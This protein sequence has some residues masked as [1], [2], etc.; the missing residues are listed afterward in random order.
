MSVNSKRQ[1][2]HRIFFQSWGGG[3]DS[4]FEYLIK[5]AR[6]SNTNDSTFADS[7]VAAVESSVKTLIKVSRFYGFLPGRIADDWRD[8]YCGRSRVLGGH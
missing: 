4:F 3:S 7:W 5:Y 6:L 1:T 2:P 8:V